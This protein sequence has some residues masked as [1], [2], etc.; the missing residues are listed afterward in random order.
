MQLETK[1]L[2]LFTAVTLGSRFGDWCVCWRGGWSRHRLFYLVMLVRVEPSAQG[3]PD[4]CTVEARK[5]R[6]LMG[7]RSIAG[8]S[9]SANY[10]SSSHR[11][12]I[13]FSEF[14][15]TSLAMRALRSDP[16]RDGGKSPPKEHA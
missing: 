12:S 7:Q 8:S 15:E 9:R 6:L 4:P 13:A 2:R 3:S 1:Y 10:I 16:C 14:P 5:P 11:Y